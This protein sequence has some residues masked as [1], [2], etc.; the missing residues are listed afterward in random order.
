[1]F[2]AA[3]AILGT[4]HDKQRALAPVLGEALGLVVDVAPGLDTDRLGTFTRERPRR[5]TALEA[6]RAKA[7][8]ALECDPHA[9]FGLASE[10]S[11]GPHPMVPWVPGG[12]ELVL[13]VR[14]DGGLE[15][16][17]E[18]ITFETNFAHQVVRDLAA[19]RAF[20]G[21]VGFPAHGLVVIPAP[22]GVA[23]TV[24][25]EK[26]L[27][28]DALFER[29]AAILAEVGAVHL[30]TDMRA[31][32]NPTRMAS[33]R[34]AAEDL[35]A[36]ARSTCP[37]CERPGFWVAERLPGLPCEACGLPTRIVRA[38]VHACAGCGHGEERPPRHGRTAASAGECDHCNP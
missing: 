13:L 7:L 17:G 14:R 35:A 28:G 4:K 34:R 8:L 15:L 20:A 30:E 32:R 23:G 2:R 29:V 12:R 33:I 36:R 26:D 1:M 22:D 31:H 16:V 3:R 27:E 24:G 18:D 5:G 10:G 38:E 25:I 9:E 11:F 21:R 37:R 19:A 6:A